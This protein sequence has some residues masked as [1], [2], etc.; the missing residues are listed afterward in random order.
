MEGTG[1]FRPDR[2]CQAPTWTAPVNLTGDAQACSI[3]VVV[4]DGHGKSAN[5]S[6]FETV[7]SVPHTLTFTQPPTGTPG[8]VASGGTMALSTAAEDSLLHT[9][10]YTWSASCP[11]AMG[12][13][14]TFTPAAN[15]QNPT[16]TAPANLTGVA[17]ACTLTVAP[18]TAAGPALA[19]LHGNGEP[20]PEHGHDHGGADGDAEPGGSAGAVALS[21]TA[22]DELGRALTYAWSASCPAAF[23]GSGTFAPAASV[24][25]PTWTAPANLTGT[26]QGCTLTVTV[27][28]GFGGERDA[29]LHRDGEPGP[30]HGD[31]HGRADGDA[32]PRGF[33][34]GGGAERDG[35]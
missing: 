33:C 15:A 28:D 23:G 4:D 3:A 21:V 14:G 10:G 29:G 5:A 6:F 8:T 22:S 17:Q 24:R 9:I 20:R 25:T 34:R 13:T 7:N 11:A 16:W 12:G 30:E 31:D 2:T 26:A 27:G 35:E 19:G 32:E 18:A 1:R